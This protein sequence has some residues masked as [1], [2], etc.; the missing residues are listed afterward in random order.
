MRNQQVKSSARKAARGD[1]SVNTHDLLLTLTLTPRLL[2]ISALLS[3]H[4][5]CCLLPLSL[6]HLCQLAVRVDNR[7]LFVAQGLQTHCTG[8]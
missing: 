1:S 5:S 2:I 3:C 8:E 6:L 4:L 7:I